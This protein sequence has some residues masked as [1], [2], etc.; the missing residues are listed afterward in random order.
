MCPACEEIDLKKIIAAL[1]PENA[2]YKIEIILEKI[3]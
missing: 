2:K 3:K 1:N